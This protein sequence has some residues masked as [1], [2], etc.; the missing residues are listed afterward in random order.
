MNLNPLMI[1]VTVLKLLL[2]PFSILYGAIMWLRNKLYDSGVYSSV[3]F[4]VPVIS[5]GNLSTG[6][7]GKTP[8][9]EYLIRLLQYEYRVATQS[10]GYKRRSRGFKMAGDQTTAFEI[11]DEPMQFHLKFP[12]VAVSVCEERM[13]GIPALLAERPDT[14]IVLLDDAYQ[15]RSVKAGLN[16]LITDYAKPFYTDHV[17]PFGNLREHR[18]AYKR[19]HAI[20]VSKCPEDLTET[21]RKEMI[22]K[23]RPLDH[24]RVFFTKIQYGGCFDFFSGMPVP[25]QPNQ[26]M[27]LVSG[28]AKP[29]PMLAYLREQVAEVHLLRY[30]DHHYFTQNN[31]EEIRQTCANWKEQHPVMVTTEKDATRLALHAETLKSWGVTIL[32]LPI[33]IAFIQDKPVFDRMVQDYIDSERLNSEPQQENFQEIF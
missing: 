25:L 32:V 13:T 24:Q 5:V 22:A 21:D 23:I 10:R 31:L 33:E 18:N 8:H 20:I 16:I 28:I 27:I 29:E 11:G 1:F 7:T 4:S 17:L 2:Y 14:D 12:E 30:P 3:S 9:I 15:H 26:H 19:A 6:G